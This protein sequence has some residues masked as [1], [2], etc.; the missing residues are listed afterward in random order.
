MEATG[1]W[2]SVLYSMAALD[3]TAAFAAI[4]LLMP[5]RRKMAEADTKAAAA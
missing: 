5:M 2:S 1:T 4:F 3:L